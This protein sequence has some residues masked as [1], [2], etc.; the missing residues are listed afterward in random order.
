MARNQGYFDAYWEDKDGTQLVKPD[1]TFVGA[2]T[3]KTNLDGATVLEAGR[4]TI[5][6]SSHIAKSGVLMVIPSSA[7]VG[8]NGSVTGL[9]AFPVALG[10][11]F[12]YFPAG[13]LYAGSVAGFYY[14]D[15]TST[16]TATVYAYRWTGGIPAFPTTPT[17]IV[18]TGPGAYTQTTGVD[19]TAASFTVPGGYLGING[20]LFLYPNFGA[21]T[22][23]NAKSWSAKY[24]NNVLI[25][26]SNT[27]T[28]MDNTP[29]VLRAAGRADRQ[30][31]TAYAGLTA[32]AG[33]LFGRFSVDSTVAQE[34]IITMKLAT[35][36]DF[37]FLQGYEAVLSF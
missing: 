36:T 3:A 13:A 1:G 7:S 24:A 10:G 32:N 11:C 23:A 6:P 25:G 29:V 26:R 35:A 18:A 33:A 15:V 5:T 21:N 2:V 30:I 12:A 17:P 14:T 37:M 8:N 20:S 19:I 27:T 31:A 22:T 4:V 16:T 28:S 34:Y 9:T